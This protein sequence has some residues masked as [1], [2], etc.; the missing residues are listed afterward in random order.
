MKHAREKTKDLEDSG[1]KHHS[2]FAK[3]L[4]M[5]PV[6]YWPRLLYSDIESENFYLFD[7]AA[8]I[9]QKPKLV[10]VYPS[11]QA[12]LLGVEKTTRRRSEV[13]DV[14]EGLFGVGAFA[15]ILYTQDWQV[16][17]E[18]QTISLFGKLRYDLETETFNF[19]EVIGMYKGDKHKELLEAFK[20]RRFEDVLA[21]FGWGIVLGLA[22]WTV[23]KVAKFTKQLVLEHLARQRQKQAEAELAM[24]DDQERIEGAPPHTRKF[25]D[26]KA[27]HEQRTL[28]IDAYA[29]STC[30]KNPRTIVMLPC[31]HCELCED[32]FRK[33]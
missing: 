7:K 14:L 10:K 17:Y 33:R 28:Y 8:P 31:K 27:T 21:I 18:G 11:K 9:T 1:F 19:D 2:V 16:V 30:K 29:C 26:E 4:Y 3:N 12:L 32:C 5:S 23:Y 22:S 15:R 13:N 24:K 6:W 25:C 20:S